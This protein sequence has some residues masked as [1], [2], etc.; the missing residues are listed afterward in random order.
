MEPGGQWDVW[1]LS[2][3]CRPFLTL[4][5]SS[6]GSLPPSGFRVVW[7]MAAADPRLRGWGGGKGKGISLPF[8]PSVS[9]GL[10]C[11]YRS[12]LKV[13]PSMVPCGAGCPCCGQSSFH[14]FPLSLPSQ[15]WGRSDPCCAFHRHHQG[16]SPLFKPMEPGPH[17]PFLLLGRRQVVSAFQRRP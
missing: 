6:P 8:S 2:V 1:P 11:G 3:E 10:L 5:C 9:S 14:L 4:S 13:P 12:H 15:S 7:S 16:A 17:I